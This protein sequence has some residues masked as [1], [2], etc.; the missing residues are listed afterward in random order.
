MQSEWLSNPQWWFDATPDIDKVITSKFGNLLDDG[1]EVVKSGNDIHTIIEN[2]LRYDQLP[3][4]VFRGTL[5]NHVIMYFHQKALKFVALLT[6]TMLVGMDDVY[7][8]FAMLPIRHTNDPLQIFTVM[9]KAW[10]RLMMK[11][12]CG[13]HIIKRFIKATYQRCPLHTQLYTLHDCNNTHDTHNHNTGNAIADFAHILDK[14]NLEPP[15]DNITWQVDKNICDVDGGPGGP[16]GP[17]GPGAGANDIHRN[18]IL[19]LSGGVDS[20][21]CSKLYL[22]RIRAAVHINYSNRVTADV[23]EAFVTA[24]CRQLGIP[25]YVRRI[26]EIRRGPCMENDMRDVYET[27]TRNV[28]Y[29]MYK[30]VA[31]TAFPKMAVSPI[32]MLGH[33]KDDCLE[34]IFT[35]IAHSC[36]FEN[37]EGMTPISKVDGITFVRPLLNISKTDIKKYAKAFRIPHLPNSTPAWSQRGQIRANLTPVINEWDPRFEGGMFNV[38]ET[39]RSLYKLLDDLTEKVAQDMKAKNHHE[40]PMEDLSSDILYWK[41]VFYKTT[42]KRPSEKALRNMISRLQVFKANPKIMMSHVVV[43]KNISIS[44]TKTC[45]AKPDIPYIARFLI[46][47]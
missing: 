11:R 7:W 29:A 3:R 12:E 41:L 28:R 24:W 25:L 17:E 22:S 47:S 16:E 8:C 37:L 44:F 6:D 39:M 35:N 21:V 9:E 1:E 36:H 4:H 19:S 33:N 23:E 15:I 10:Q 43:Q 13:S 46:I 5:S 31:I 45:F 40:M 2:I 20:M 26:R 14:D 42:G 27:Y 32:I 38:A 18:I 34:N 30:Q